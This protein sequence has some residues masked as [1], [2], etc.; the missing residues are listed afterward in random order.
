M[1]RD[2]PFFWNIQIARWGNPN[3]DMRKSKLRDRTKSGRSQK[4][5]IAR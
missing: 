2:D 1:M 5:Q 3:C 4:I